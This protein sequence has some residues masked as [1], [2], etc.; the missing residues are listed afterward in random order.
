MHFL[1]SKLIKCEILSEIVIFQE[2]VITETQNL[3]H[4]IWHASNPKYVPLKPFWCILPSQNPQ[5]IKF[6]LF[7]EF[8]EKKPHQFD[9][10]KVFAKASKS[11]HIG[12]CVCRLKCTMLEL[13]VTSTSLVIV[14]FC[15]FYG[16]VKIQG[17]ETWCRGKMGPQEDFWIGPI[18]F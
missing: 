10:E 7:P 9:K 5:N 3:W 6:W 14:F 11:A 17:S 13:C 12:F 1:Q 8:P 15:I 4:W 2:P 18:P 16:K